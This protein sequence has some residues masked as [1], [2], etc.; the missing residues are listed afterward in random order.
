MS[1][2]ASRSL[3]SPASNFAFQPGERPAGDLT[4]VQGLAR[5]ELG[6]TYLAEDAAGKRCVLRR[7][8]PG[9]VALCERWPELAKPSPHLVISR[10]LSSS[11]EETWLARDYLQGRSLADV[12][13]PHTGGL[14]LKEA[15]R[16][17]E[18]IAAGLHA[19]AENGAIHGR[20]K[21]SNVWLARG[22]VKLV[23]AGLRPV[24][25][26]ASLAARYAAPETSL[27]RFERAD[28]Y[29]CSALLGEMLTGQVF[30]ADEPWAERIAE[31]Y[32]PIL[33]RALDPHPA[34]R[35]AGVADL[36]AALR[37]A[38]ADL[39]P[40]PAEP[41]PPLPSWSR[42]GAGF[43]YAAGE[44]PLDGFTLLRT[45]GRGAS[46][47]VYEATSDGG[48][49][50]ALKLLQ[51]NLEV[52][53]RGM[54]E[55]LR[56]PRHEHLLQLHDVR[57]AGNGAWWVV[58]DF[59][60]G[61]SLADVLQE[62]AGPLS[63]R[64]A[65][66]WMQGVLAGLEALHAAGIVHRDLKPGNILRQRGAVKIADY[67]LAKIVSDS[68]RQGHTETVGALAY[69]APEITQGRCGREVDLYA[70]GAMLYELLTGRTPFEG[71]SAAEIL[72][73]PLLEEPDLTDVPA[74]Y[75]PV[76]AKALAKKPSERFST[77]TEM[78]EAL[79]EAESASARRPAAWPI[80]SPRFRTSHL[81]FAGAACLLLL[82]GLLSLLLAKTTAP[83]FKTAP[84]ASVLAK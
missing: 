71:E 1:L 20:L 19:L 48:K 38:P 5:G 77:A 7:L 73:K 55:C 52:E 14:R 63:P 67:G 51:R 65:A 16:W 34:R 43:T 39:P 62:A 15:L 50:V 24:R 32:R 78:R 33:R 25:C 81:W 26:E 44:R 57:Q 83:P 46:G 70:C 49:T 68:R 29:A 2:S 23:D 66:E 61:P 37:A 30:D 76:T 18:G 22:V 40:P 13:A 27:G 54:Q 45:I 8:I 10:R 60:D 84:P 31:P 47:E 56:L 58:M 36:L 59:A 80:K 4:I 42:A 72:Y 3:S 53:L 64:T 21:P 9:E 75:R 35:F 41:P 74:A 69:S 79:A 82:A 12:L 11:A 6:E 28:L 17:L